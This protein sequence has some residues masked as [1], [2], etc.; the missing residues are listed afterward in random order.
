MVGITSEECYEAAR[1]QYL[2]TGEW[3]RIKPM[4]IV[5]LEGNEDPLS[6]VAIPPNKS[7]SEP[8]PWKQGK[9]LGRGAFGSVYMVSASDPSPKGFR[10]VVVRVSG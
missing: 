2:Q 9:L 8:M 5:V 7:C 6:I 1:D 4:R 3:D 10:A